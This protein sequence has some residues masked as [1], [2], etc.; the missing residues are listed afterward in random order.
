M[1]LHFTSKYIEIYFCFGKLY[2]CQIDEFYRQ[3][4][5]IRIKRYVYS[6]ELG[7]RKF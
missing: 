3:G 7:W 1:H 5:S 4:F 2:N 6:N